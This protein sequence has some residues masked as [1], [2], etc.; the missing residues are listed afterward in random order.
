MASNISGSSDE[1][2]DDY[3]TTDIL[4]G[5]TSKELTDDP[6]NQLGGQPVSMALNAQVATFLSKTNPIEM[7]R[8][9]QPALSLGRKMQGLQPY[10][11]AAAAIER[12]STRT[13][14]RP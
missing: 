7:A 10:I 6:F 14:R 8:S 9:D 4:L 12:R 5:Y 13:I 3:T 1:E 11:D 2:L